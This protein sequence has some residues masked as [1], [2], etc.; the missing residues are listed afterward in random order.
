MLPERPFKHEVEKHKA[1]RTNRIAIIFFNQMTGI[2]DDVK[3]A[4]S[5]NS[6][7]IAASKIG[8]QNVV[9]GLKNVY[10]NGILCQLSPFFASAW[11]ADGN[12][13]NSALKYFEKYLGLLNPVS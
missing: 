10:Y 6:E 1:N 8:Y 2:F 12:F 13:P 9:K 7:G 4:G 5:R 11:Y 3:L